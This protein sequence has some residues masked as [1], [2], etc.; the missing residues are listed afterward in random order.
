MQI[1]RNYS[2]CSLTC[3]TAGN[4]VAYC[5][6]PTY[7]LQSTTHP[8]LTPVCPFKVNKGDRDKQAMA[9]LSG[10]RLDQTCMC[11]WAFW[12]GCVPWGCSLL[13]H[14]GQLLS[15]IPLKSNQRSTLLTNSLLTWL[16]L[17]S[18]NTYRT[19]Q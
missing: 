14:E 16:F 15:N 7:H 6:S 4:A 1:T 19:S 8:L 10:N 11:V 2:K 5:S 13:L 18:S 17:D 12:C 3:H 9:T